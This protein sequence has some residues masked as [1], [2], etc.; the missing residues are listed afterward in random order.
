VLPSRLP[1]FNAHVERGNGTVKYEFYFLYCGPPI[2]SIVNQRLEKFVEFSHQSL[3]YKA[4]M[5]HYKLL[6]R[7]KR[8]KERIMKIALPAIEAKFESETYIS[9]S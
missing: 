3:Q 1:K 5:E 4:P 9:L 8:K 6:L 7:E 2:L